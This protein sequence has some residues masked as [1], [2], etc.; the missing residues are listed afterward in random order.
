MV[1]SWFVEDP[2]SKLKIWQA[3]KKFCDLSIFITIARTEVI[4]LEPD[5]FLLAL[6]FRVKDIV[7]HPEL[8]QSLFSS[9]SRVIWTIETFSA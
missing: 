9:H 6:P 2:D 3:E 4:I 1:C 7:M 5:G 8:N